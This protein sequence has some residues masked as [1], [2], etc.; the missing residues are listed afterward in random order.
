M[1]LDRLRGRMPLLVFLVL[2]VVCLVLF[3]FACACLSD[4]PA[5]ALERTV[6]MAGDMPAVI[7]LWSY[8]AAVMALGALSIWTLAIVGPRERAS[9]ARLQRF[10]F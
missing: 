10:L 4:N 2:A 6:A 1:A 3:G 8:A 9:P 5:Q 7:E